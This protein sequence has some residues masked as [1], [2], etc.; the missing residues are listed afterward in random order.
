MRDDVENRFQRSGVV[1]PREEEEKGKLDILNHF[2]NVMK[3][4]VKG[5]KISVREILVG[6]WKKA[7]LMLR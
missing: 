2:L 6:F 4:Q 1:W 3:K 7:W 5:N